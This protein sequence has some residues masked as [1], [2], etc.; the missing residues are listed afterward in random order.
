[1]TPARL[2]FFG[3]AEI[4]LPSLRACAQAEWCT[5]VAVVTQPDKPIGRSQRVTPSP[6]S[7]VAHE[8]NLPVYYSASDILDIPAEYG[9]TIAYGE[10]LPS[11]ILDHFPNGILNVHPSLLPQWRGPAPIQYAL[12]HG[13]D[14]TGVSIMLID[15]H[16]D[17]GPLLAQQT[18][19]VHADDTSETLHEALGKLGAELLVQSLHAYHGGTLVPTPQSKEGVTYSHIINRETGK[20]TK[21]MTSAE[22]WRLWRALQPWP[23]IYCEWSTIRI[24]LTAVHLDGNDELV[25][26]KIQ[27]AGKSA[28]DFTAFKNGYPDFSLADISD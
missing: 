10:L 17:T 8:L 15:E 26:D 20:I 25:V 23:G 22:I 2:I 19:T 28:M 24:K 21:H 12:M 18:Y 4:A 27:P 7:Q 9:I 5:I 16:M 14:D 11:A 1:M 6:V 3:T 13:N